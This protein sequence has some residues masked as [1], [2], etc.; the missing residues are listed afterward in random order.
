MTQ[1]A[2]LV[3]RLHAAEAT[4]LLRFFRRGLGAGQDAR[5][6]VQETFLRLLRV[7]RPD[8]IENPQ[9]YLY[10]VA[11]S[12]AISA[13]QR[14]GAERALFVDHPEASQTAACD[15]PGAERQIAARQELLLMARAIQGLPRRCQQVFILSR[16]HG[17]ANGAIAA[18]LGISRNMVEKHI[19]RAL[20][21]CR[22]LQRELRRG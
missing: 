7:P 9:A 22:A 12:V 2:D 15:A 8:Q 21:T 10:A 16:L 5:D 13:G 17:L 4:R 18:Q 11:R 19:M 1:A 6:A 20:L 3:R 14:A